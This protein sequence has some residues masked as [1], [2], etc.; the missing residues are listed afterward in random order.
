MS[1]RRMLLAMNETDQRKV[2]DEEA[3][4]W[5]FRNRTEDSEM[6][7]LVLAMPGSFDRQWGLEVWKSV[8]KPL[9]NDPHTHIHEED[10]VHELTVR[11]F[12]ILETCQN[13]GPSDGDALWRTRTRACIETTA[14]LV[15]CIGGDRGHIGDFV[16]LLSD[17]G[18]DQNV[19]ESSSLGRDRMFVMRWTCLSLVAIQSVLASD[20]N[21][22]NHA[23]QAISSLTEDQYHT[24]KR[25][26]PTRMIAAFKK[27]LGCIE[28]LS[29]ALILVEDIKE[30]EAR[31]ILRGHESA[32]STLLNIGNQ[33]DD[34]ADTRIQAVQ[35][36]LVKI[37]HRII[38]QLP[39]IKFADPDAKSPNLSELEEP[40]PN[41]LKE[42][43]RDPHKF[44]F[45]TTT[46]RLKSF[47][48]IARTFQNL[49]TGQWNKGTFKE[50]TDDLKKVLKLLR[51]NPLRREV[52]RL[53]DLCEGGGLGFTVE[54]FFL[55]RK[56]LLST[57]LS[58]EY[59]SALLI[60]TFK[61]ITSD[62]QSSDYKSSLG[63]QQLL[64][65]L[66]L[67]DNNIIFGPTDTY[68]DNII[69]EFFSLLG[70]VLKG[71]SGLHIEDV[72]RQLTD[73]K[74]GSYSTAMRRAFYQ[75][76]LDVIKEAKAS[77]PSS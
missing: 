22:Q 69:D 47:S 39:G 25:Q 1:Q 12:R 28:E 65:D 21:L 29:D 66:V 24:G 44:Q 26:T 40:E 18:K 33:C 27:A 61:A 63:T 6:E 17:I 13:R 30:E 67:S 60:G 7:S 16:V 42:S 46:H 37:T 19:R 70:T 9:A 68:P 14:S 53:Q 50:G 20:R 11:A 51:G 56:Q 31:M 73:E 52:W 3:I 45:V 74:L 71:Q 10:I 48:Q 23:S 5:L 43:Y 58:K 35:R 77:G 76:A 2:R 57:S 4:R 41:Q 54:L 32:I 59:H 49:Y 62:S 55:A 34:N 64:L 38:C 36:D 75:K 8:S 15:F 72:V